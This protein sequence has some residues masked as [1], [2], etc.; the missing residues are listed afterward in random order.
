MAQGPFSA[1]H[2]TTTN[3]LPTIL[4]SCP[5]ILTSW[6][7]TTKPLEG[8][9][10]SGTWSNV[11]ITTISHLQGCL[12]AWNEKMHAL[13]GTNVSHAIRFGFRMLALFWDR[14]SKSYLMDMSIIRR[15]ILVQEI[16]R[17]SHHS[18]TYFPWPTWPLPWK[19]CFHSVNLSFG[20]VGTCNRSPHIL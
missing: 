8:V 16:V 19:M 6:R 12:G 2:F 1:H 20:R 4:T 5:Y 14:I 3:D 11:W 18:L 13:T 9:T 7:I 17:W 10:C 15:N